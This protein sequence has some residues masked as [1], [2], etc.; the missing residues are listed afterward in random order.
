MRWP[1]MAPSS[2]AWTM[3]KS[4]LQLQGHQT[5]IRETWK[6]W[7]PGEAG[8]GTLGIH[9]RMTRSAAQ[10]GEAQLQL[11]S[12][13]DQPAAQVKEETQLQPVSCEGVAVTIGTQVMQNQGEGDAMKVNEATYEE[14]LS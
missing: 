3:R 6:A 7:W 2:P 14:C 10:A 12:V 13:N 4:Q 9:E 8:P 5:G 1:V 11:V